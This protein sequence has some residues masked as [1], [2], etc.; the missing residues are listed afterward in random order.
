MAGGGEDR[1]DD[2]VEPQYWLSVCNGMD[3]AMALA[4]AA[5]GD[6][7][8]LLGVIMDFSNHPLAVLP[9]FPEALEALARSQ[10]DAEAARAYSTAA[11]MLRS[12]QA[13]NRQESSDVDAVVA[14]QCAAQLMG[15]Q[16]A[17][18]RRNYAG[19]SGSS[20]MRSVL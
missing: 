1:L 4:R 16:A 19:P 15:E 6:Q 9:E 11:E 17:E 13:F 20:W 3:T 12:W 18:P 10:K 8:E 5:T 14:V 7:S 2:S